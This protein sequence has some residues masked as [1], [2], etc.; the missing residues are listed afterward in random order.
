MEKIPIRYLGYIPR[1]KIFS[2]LSRMQI[3]IAPSTKD[4]AREVASPIKIFEYMATGLPV[5]TPKIGDF[6]EMIAEE[7]CGIALQQDD[8]ISYEEALNMLSKKDIWMIKSNNA[9]N[10]IRR[11]YNWDNTLKV[12]VNLILN[13]Q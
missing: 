12:I 8:I 1:Q 5:I 4:L 7:D 13:Y 10:A 3:G 11:K 6:G 2:V 9:I